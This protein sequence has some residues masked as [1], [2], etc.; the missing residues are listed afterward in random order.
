M[1]GPEEA[2]T[3]LCTLFDAL[4]NLVVLLAPVTPF[5]TEHI[6][7]NLA[8]ALPE[9]HKMKAKSVH[10]VMV[11]DPD[12]EALNP[13]IVTAVGRMQSVVELGR[14]CREHKHVGLKMPLK[15]MTVVSKNEAF[16]SDVKS[17][18][19][20]MVEELNVVEVSYRSE[21]EG[22]S[23]TANLNFKLLG[24]KVGKD[25]KAVQEAAKNL[26]Q[27]ELKTFEAEGKITLGGHVISSDEMQVSSQLASSDDANIGSVADDFTSVIMDFSYDEDLARMAVCRDVANRVQK[28][29]KD[30][31]LQQDDPVDMWADVVPSQKSTGMLQK[32]MTEKRDYINKLLRRPLWSSG[33]LDGHEVVVAREEFELDSA[34]GDV[35]VV[36]ITV[37]GAFFNAKAL[38][39][40]TGG[41]TAAEACCRQY[42][43]TFAIGNFQNVCSKGAVKVTYDSKTFEMIPNKHFAWGPAEALWLGK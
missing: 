35:L 22:V 24:K 12:P 38:A 16:I 32:A 5:L 6:Y 2:L 25:M 19:A 18:Q 30:T 1:N 26:S 9:G 36:S 7:Q 21:A 23:L 43:Q 40:L 8:R 17:L 20:Y 10:F 39:E 33:M 13:Q 11:P 14:V 28:L 41:D 29:R 31:K 4:L 37:R 3:A 15:S 34:G 42:L 27:E